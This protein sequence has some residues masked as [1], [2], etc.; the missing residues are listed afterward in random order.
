MTE[1]VLCGINYHFVPVAIR[2]RFTIPESCLGHALE[3]LKRLPHIKEAAILSTCN[4][5]E[6]YALVSDIQAGWEEI[7]SFFT[8]AQTV[9]DHGA[10]KPN[11][12][13]L[14]EDVALHLLRVAAGLDS[15]VVGEGQILH[16]VKAAHQ[17]ALSSGAAGPM[18][19]S[20]FKFAIS[21]GKRVR[22]ETSMGRRAVSISSAA[23]EL[24]RELL[25]NLSGKSVLVIG[26]G[27][28]GQI[29]LKLLLCDNSG[30][31][32]FVAN[33]SQ[34][35]IDRF[36]NNN[37]RNLDRLKVIQDFGQRHL[38]ATQADL[39]IVAS[40]A[41]EHVLNFEALKNARQKQGSKPPLKIIDIAVP[42]NVDPEIAQLEQVNL[43]NADDLSTIV[44]RNLAERESL[45]S[46][47]EKIVFAILKDFQNWQRNLLV[48]PT[49][50]HLRE[51]IEA[52][53]Q[54]QMEKSCTTGQ[55]T[56]GPTDKE[57]LEEISRAIVNQILHHPTK[58][59]KATS[60]Y[61]ILRQ[62]AEALRVLF[63]LDPISTN[64]LSKSKA[65]RKSVLV[66][67]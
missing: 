33:R 17:A 3:A 20:L 63:D 62:Q 28:M 15:M 32:V 44:N 21:C 59:L 52:I 60:D 9:I 16:Q 61:E 48:V 58:Q 50:A 25:G 4:R 54:A 24:G 6:V 57:D 10:L 56:K 19:D 65:K 46:E 22:S 67:H 29:C 30:G 41:A 23:V 26:A 36:L 64:Q 47:A 11:F 18:L 34:E 51:K 35:R 40:S 37:V 66:K 8:S 5:T 14:R 55:D 31:S 12:R 38:A 13:L 27:K 45:V 2:E 49:I 7:E 42:R 1:L 53:R 39:V 43:Y